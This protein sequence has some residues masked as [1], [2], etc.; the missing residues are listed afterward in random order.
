MKKQKK[1][2]IIGAGPCGLGAAWRLTELG[3]KN[4]QIYEKNE[5]GGIA[6]TY[7]DEAFSWDVGAHILYS[8]NN[9]F[10]NLLAKILPTYAW[11]AHRREAWIWKENM[12]MPYP[13][14][15]NIK[16]LNKD[17]LWKCIEGLIRRKKINPKNFE[18]W[19]LTNFG[20]GIAK[21]FM[22]PYN[23][24]V[25][26]TSPKEMSYSWIGE[27][28]PTPSVD[29]ILKN[30]I[31]D[32]DD[33]HWGPNDMFNYPIE[34][35]GTVWDRIWYKLPL[36]NIR[37][38]DGSKA[39][40][41]YLIDTRPCSKKLKYQSTYVFG[42]GILGQIPDILKDKMWVYF[43]EK[44][45][46]F[47][48]VAIHSNFSQANAGAGC[49]SLL[50]ECSKPCHM[51]EAAQALWKIGF[52]KGKIVKKWQHLEKYGYPIPTI[53][54]DQLLKKIRGDEKKGIY[55]RGRFGSWRYE[56]GNMDHSFMQGVEVINKILK[57]KKETI[58]DS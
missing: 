12:F 53:D 10:N 35:I 19:I 58:Y 36:D 44:E 2:V 41:D 8:K 40:Y 27:R 28:V 46:P 17:K 51:I 3:Y 42:F 6:Q 56:I 16:W 26:A 14:Q 13:F 54:R 48:R 47:Y 32:K 34:G 49:Y 18:E 23:E 38:G 24:K 22:I 15:N 57:G 9:Y 52:I 37:R 50:V 11:R 31:L 29:E 33:T 30:V 25:W 5:V 43:P 20:D 4:W 45:Y 39:H 55:H 7:R 21:E 1:I